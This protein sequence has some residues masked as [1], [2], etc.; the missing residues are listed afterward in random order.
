MS[1][2]LY[3][4][5]A[6]DTD[7]G[8]FLS[9]GLFRKRSPDGGWE[10]L[11]GRFPM[12]PEVRAILTDPA[13]P[14]RVTVGTQRG[15]FRSDDAGD[16]WR[17]LPAPPAG[18]AVWSLQ[19]HPTEPD[20]LLAGYEPAAVC[21]SRD[22]GRTWERLPT[23]ASYPHVTAG[24]EMPKRITGLAVTAGRPAALYCSIE[25]GGLLRS[26][27][28]GG[29]WEAAIDGVYV[30]EDAVDLHGVVVHP[31]RTAEVT[32]TTRVGTFRSDDGGDHWRKLPVPALR[33]KGSYCRALA[34]APG[35]PDTLYVGAGNDFD[36]DKGAL[37]VSED[38][39][40][41]WQAVP[42]P[43]P[44]KST[45]FGIAV[46]P[47]HPD[48]LHC[49]TKNG[50]VFSS[51]DRGRSWAYAPLPAGAGHVFSLALG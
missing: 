47:R 11:D 7:E 30:A 34:Y 46:N 29:T 40:G 35:R 5:V 43:G 23:A 9:A 25:I 27:D 49:A 50:G 37:F 44:L 36:G 19:R 31:V 41:S 42:L 39:G 4:G 22:D 24:P 32:I 1:T 16:S 10:R 38:D 8:R 17:S 20:V 45:V 48:S 33:E 12:P 26:R 51:H 3:A 18:L 13:R 2:C 15:I 21:R 14:G 6:G 28:D